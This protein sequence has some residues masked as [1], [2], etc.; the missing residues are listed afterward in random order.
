MNI[1]LGSNTQAGANDI[2]T[3]ILEKNLTNFEELPRI[4]LYFHIIRRC[5]PCLYSISQ[6]IL[7]IV[8]ESYHIPYNPSQIGRTF[9]TLS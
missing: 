9:V 3:L 6:Y 8:T 5:I 1:Y 4:T 2:L 7:Y